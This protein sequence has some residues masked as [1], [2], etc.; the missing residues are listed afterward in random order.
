MEIEIEVQ[1]F[2]GKRFKH[3]DIRN[4]LAHRDEG[5]SADGFI[6]DSLEP[7]SV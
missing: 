1:K 5:R 3:Y 7:K 2:L 4:I 6:S